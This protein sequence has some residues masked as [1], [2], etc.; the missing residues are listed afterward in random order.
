MVGPEDFEPDGQDGDVCADDDKKILSVKFDNSFETYIEA[1]G[2]LANE[3]ADSPKYC[4][5]AYEKGGC[6]GCVEFAYTYD[7]ADFGKR[8]KE[9]DWSGMPPR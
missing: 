1:A 9:S 2:A 3:D 6:S 5:W 4:I 8:Q 7:W